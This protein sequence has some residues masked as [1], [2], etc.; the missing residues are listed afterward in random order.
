MSDEEYN[1]W[2][3]ELRQEYWE[4][5]ADDRRYANRSAEDVLEDIEED[6][7][8]KFGET[9]EDIYNTIKAELSDYG[10]ECSTD[11]IFENIIS[12]S[13]QYISS[14]KGTI[15]SLRENIKTLNVMLTQKDNDM[16]YLQSLL[17]EAKDA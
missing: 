15:K 13:T 9:L 6:M 4:E 8:D 12:D 10:L 17:K 3:E 1:E 2:R 5:R 7:S 16:T 11:D 14:A